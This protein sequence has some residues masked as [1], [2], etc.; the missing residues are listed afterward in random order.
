MTG[1][2]TLLWPFLGFL[3]VAALMSWWQAHV[4]RREL[5]TGKSQR[6]QD[7]ARFRDRQDEIARFNRAK[8]RRAAIFAA[9]GL[10][11]LVLLT[12]VD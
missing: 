4:A 8:R 3:T 10:A 6:D 7:G 12:V 5:E 2:A 9:L 1:V 11:V